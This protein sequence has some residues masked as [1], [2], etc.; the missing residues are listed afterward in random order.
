MTP[1]S[2]PSCSRASD[3]VCAMSATALARAIA[4]RELSVLDVLM[5]FLNRIDRINP[6]VNA[7]VTLC[8]EEAL[9]QATAMDQSFTAGTEKPLY[10]LPIAIK[11]LVLTRG[12][13]TTMGS[14]IYAD[15]VP[16][17]DELYIE[18]LKAAG[19]I[20]I[21]KT[22]T[23]EFGAGSQT[24][25]PVFGATRNPYDLTRTCGGSSGGAAV[26]LACEMLP[27]ADGNDLGGSLRNPASFCNVVGFRP[28]PGRVP[29]WPKQFSSDQ[30]GVTGPMARSVEDAALLLSVM[31]GP[32]QRVPIS[33]SEP[34]VDFL[35]PLACDVKGMRFAWSSDLGGNPVD[36]EVTAVLEQALP[37]FED[38]GGF[39]DAADPDLQDAEE[40]F[41][42]FRAWMF[43]AKFGED[44]RER[45]HL[46]KDTVRWNIEE[47][48]KLTLADL[49]AATTKH[50]T[51]VERIARFFDI[52]DILLCPSAQVPP[53]PLVQEWV[54][55]I[56]GIELETYLDWMAVCWAITV[57]GCPAISVP[58]GFTESGLPVG[59]QIVGARGRDRQVLE[60]AY[61]F[62]QV[63]QQARRRPALP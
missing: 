3:T 9:A 1:H 34:G 57:T 6:A 15:F 63:T 53:F 19:A 50:A 49:T 11:D 38:L 52:Y 44:Y 18:R 23:P 54:H 31:A 37:V 29:N 46:M 61:A 20:I 22:N 13:R 7:I 28:T 5:A 39:I 30:F 60:V 2:D 25:N 36:P 32:D 35:G 16:D 33:L 26:A 48:L 17:I 59:I 45:A 24:F 4:D 51:L 41:S 42:T 21:G 55:S 14:P 47:G 56:N 40:I 12:I 43:L 58:A 8:P 62:E 10:G 27:I